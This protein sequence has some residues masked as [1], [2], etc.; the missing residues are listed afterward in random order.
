MSSELWQFLSLVEVRCLGRF[1][2]PQI[3]ATLVQNELAAI[4]LITYL[5][6]VRIA[7]LLVEFGPAVASLFSIA[8]GL[9]LYQVAESNV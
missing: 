5:R 9:E 3:N 7:Q 4:A 2:I 6:I 8:I 1:L